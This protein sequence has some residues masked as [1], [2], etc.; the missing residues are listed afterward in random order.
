MEQRN[1][2]R[3]RV[4]PECD[5]PL[6]QLTGR[7]IGAF[8]DVHRAF[9]YGFLESVYRRALG[10]EL[11]Y[12]GIAVAQEV[13]YEIVHRGV[14]VGIYRADMVAESIIV[15]ETKTGLLLDPVAPGQLLNYLRASAL[16][17]GLVLHFGPRASVKR[18]VAS[19]AGVI[20]NLR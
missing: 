12:R 20:E 13:P 15:L 3:P 8:L 5:Y 6:Q 16:P 18:V 2:G 19:R 14:P 10:V 9:G 11:A 4:F 7:I 17:V 1:A